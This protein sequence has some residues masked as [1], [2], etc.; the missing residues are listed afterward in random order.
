MSYDALTL[1]AIT[2]IFVFIIVIVLVGR[3]R[4]ATEMRMRNLARNLLM[5]Q[6]SEDAREICQ[7]IHKKYPDLCAGIDFT[8]RDEGNGV[9]IDEWNSDKPRPEV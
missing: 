8:F 5:M 6:S 9:E 3:N 7:K 1:S 4:A 2:I